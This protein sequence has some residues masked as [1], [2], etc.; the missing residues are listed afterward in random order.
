MKQL[1]VDIDDDVHNKFI[2]Q[3]PWGF[4]GQLIRALIQMCIDIVVIHGLEV[5]PAIINK[6]CHIV[7]KENK[8]GI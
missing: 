3:I 7:Y 5:I 8:D 6:K 2:K 1:R 4:T